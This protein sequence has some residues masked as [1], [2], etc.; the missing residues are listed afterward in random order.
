MTNRR[1]ISRSYGVTQRSAGH[2]HGESV[3][4]T[5]VKRC[6]SD[7]LSLKSTL[8]E[9]TPSRAE[10]SFDKRGE[11]FFARGESQDSSPM[12]GQADRGLLSEISGLPGNGNR[13]RAGG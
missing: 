9:P 12:H 11:E 5:C 8:V 7:A 10:P 6:V 13:D 4:R 3:A 2:D 1:V